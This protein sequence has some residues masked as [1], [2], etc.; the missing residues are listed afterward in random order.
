M[1]I[2]AH[3]RAVASPPD[4]LILLLA[5]VL[6]QRLAAQGFALFEKDSI[7][8]LISS[9]FSFTEGPAADRAGNI[10]FTDQPN[11]RIWKYD[12]AGR[13]SV[14]VENAG[15]SNGLFFDPAGNLIACADERNE[16][17]SISPEGK[18]TVLV[19]GFAGRMLNGP[20]DVWVHQHKGIY[21]TDPYYQRDYWTRKASPLPGGEHLY[22]YSMKRGTVRVADTAF[23]K[24]NG[25]VGMS[26][27]RLLYVSDIGNRCI[28][29]YRLGR[30]GRLKKKQ[31]FA[32]ELCD[33]MTIDEKGNVYLAGNGVTVYSPGGRK[34]AHI[35]VPS[36]W[37]ANLCFGGANGNLLF[38]T[39]SESVYVIPMKVRGVRD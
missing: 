17:W 38:I 18:V 23:K 20:N 13:L 4:W 2:L 32:R 19:N 3:R 33:G 7:P 27:K 30:N 25:V 10:F 1:H 15:Q 29:R 28:F 12:T 6:Q 26:A 31:L 9:Q 22:Y 8:I 24:P 37:T 14:F 36:A 35:K 39:A 11:N 5:L 16:L 21:F 34:L